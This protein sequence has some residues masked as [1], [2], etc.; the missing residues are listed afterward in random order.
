MSADPTANGRADTATGPVGTHRIEHIE[1]VALAAPFADSFG[2]DD[3]V[4]DWLLHP[5]AS[6]AVLPRRGQYSTLVFIRTDTGAVGVGESYGL[7]APEVTATIIGTVL[8]PLLLGTDPLAGTS[9]WETMYRAQAAGGH[10]RGYYLEALA[11]IDLAL[12]DLRGKLL[13]VPVHQLL[14]GPTR[15][16]IDCYA[17]PVPHLDQPED[18]ATRALEFAA[19]GFRAVKVKVGRGVERDVSHLAAVRSALAP[20]IEVMVDANC[21]YQLDSATRLG[22]HLAEVGITWYEEPLAVDDLA[23]LA[24]LRRRTG[25]S[26]VN[27]ETHF[28]RFDVRDSLLHGSI[29][30]VMPNLTRCGGLTEALRIA[31]LASAFHVDVSP[32]GVGSGIGLCAALQ[33]MAAIPNVRAYEYNQLPNPLRHDL[34]AQPPAFADGRLALPPGPGLG[35]DLNQDTVD[36]YTTFR[37]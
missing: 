26:I 33:L 37:I 36:R 11:G 34:L 29:D 17:S 9:A 8:R 13:G 5:A 2:G 4:P 31:A 30:V 16:V 15:E 20:G 28:T 19:M 24:E 14:G 1:A 32:H 23:S 35:F 22:R 21:A 6:H 7:P 3:Q 27:G 25:L 18:T 12:W 10:N